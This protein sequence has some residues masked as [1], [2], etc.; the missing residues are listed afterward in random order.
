[1]DI[2]LQQNSFNLRPNNLE[3]L[4]T[5]HLRIT[6][7]GL[8]VLLSPEQSFINET[9]RPQGHIKKGLKEC[10]YIHHCNICWHLVSY[11]INVYSYDSSKNKQNDPD[12]PEPADERDTQMNIPPTS[13]T[14]Q[15]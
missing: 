10:P 2:K 7:P 4:I 12:D 6:I 1:M 5:Q 9:G 3:I 11:S 13:C 8:E 15:V 14:A